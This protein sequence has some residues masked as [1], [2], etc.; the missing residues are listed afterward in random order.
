ML[1]LAC[2]GRDGVKI[3]D[4]ISL[5]EI[6]GPIQTS[7]ARGQTSSLAWAT[8]VEDECERLC[9]GTGLGYMV[10]WRRDK[11]VR[12]L[13]TLSNLNSRMLQNIFEEACSV[14]VGYGNEITS[15]ACAP[16]T[17]GDPIRIGLGTRDGMVQAWTFSPENT[18][19]KVFSIELHDTVIGGISFLECPAKHVQVFSVF[20]GKT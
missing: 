10:I 9:Y 6:P 16:P 1:T 7:Q 8:R 12:K 5:Q 2:P 18:L 4:L 19:H 13:I 14:R 3:W 17:I 15:I 20:D 11:E